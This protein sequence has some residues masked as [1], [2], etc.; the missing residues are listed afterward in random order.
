DG[1]LRMFDCV[2]FNESF[3]WVDVLSDLAFA[4]MDFADF[5]RA[6]FAHRLLDSYLQITGDYASL[7]TWRYYFVYRALVR[8]KVAAI[9]S[10]QADESEQRTAAEAELQ[11]YLNLAEQTTQNACPQLII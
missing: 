3:R 6:D 10:T 7:A 11:K 2:E 8:A 9:R 4:C 1:A 5:G